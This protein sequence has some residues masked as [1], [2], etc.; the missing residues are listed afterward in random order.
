LR[1]T[2]VE[3]EG[4]MA[5]LVEKVARAIGPYDEKAVRAAIAVVLWQVL[6]WELTKVPSVAIAEGIA[7][8]NGIELSQ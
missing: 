4:K 6:K 2:L 1:A 5:D 8:E 3:T 7:R